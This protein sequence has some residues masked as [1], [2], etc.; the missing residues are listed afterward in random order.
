M[1]SPKIVS[2]DVFVV[3]LFCVIQIAEGSICKH[4]WHIYFEG[5]TAKFIFLCEAFL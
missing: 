1:E 5:V 3:S 4:T 2:I